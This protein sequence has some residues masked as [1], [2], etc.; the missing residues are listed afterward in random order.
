MIVRSGKVQFL[1]WTAFF[2]IMIYLILIVIGLETFVLP[3]QKPMEI[4]YQTVITMFSLY[5]VLILAVLSGVVLS[6]MIDN[7]FYRNLFGTFSAI[8]FFSLLAVKGMFG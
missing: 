6:V 8:V 4:P 3:K 7:H 1:F 2:S 5:G